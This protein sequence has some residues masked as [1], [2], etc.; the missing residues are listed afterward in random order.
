MTDKERRD[1]TRLSRA[2]LYSGTGRAASQQSSGT[3]AQ[4][5]A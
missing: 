1:D 4:A 5:N 3:Y 2:A